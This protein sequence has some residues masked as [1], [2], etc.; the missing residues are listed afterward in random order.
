MADRSQLELIWPIIEVDG[1]VAY[2]GR[3]EDN[4]VTGGWARD[5]EHLTTIATNLERAGFNVYTHLNRSEH[6]RSVKGSTRHI[7]EWRHL[8]IDVDPVGDPSQIGD[9]MAR[10]LCE[11]PAR[12][13]T[14]I[15]SGRGMQA[16]VRMIEMPTPDAESRARV[17]RSMSALLR[18]VAT[19]ADLPGCKVDSGCSDL[20]RVARLPGTINTKTGRMAQLHAR[21][22]SRVHPE[23]V[24]AHDPGQ[25]EP[26][27]TKLTN[28]CRFLEVW[29]HLTLT[30]ETFMFDGMVEPGRHNAAIATVR[31]LRELG[32]PMDVAMG[33]A[34]TGAGRCRPRLDQG[35]IERTVR[36][37]YNRRGGP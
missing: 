16:W 17:E 35:Y 22:S 7:T 20:A 4:R 27:A 6:K 23:W 30:A 21:Y 32:V 37:E 36:S 29:P 14:I 13:S 3:R 19:V 31:N 34:L 1:Q 18:K 33:W 2:F 10:A 5:P 24:L 28:P 26:I 12:G 11:L 25:P 8:F 15:D 9:V